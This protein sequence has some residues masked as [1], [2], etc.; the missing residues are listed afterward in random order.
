VYDKFNRPPTENEAALDADPYASATLMSLFIIINNKEEQLKVPNLAKMHLAVGGMLKTRSAMSLR[1][2][3][4]NWCEVF[5][6]TLNKL[7]KFVPLL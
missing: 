2:H 7:A 6:P 3:T 1:R 4:S 5:F